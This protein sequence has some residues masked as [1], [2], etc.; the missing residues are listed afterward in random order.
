MGVTAIVISAAVVTAPF[1]IY[2]AIKG[3]KYV[4]QVIKEK[5][6][7]Q[8][9]TKNTGENLAILKEE[10]QSDL[11]GANL[12]M[13]GEDEVSK[14]INEIRND[15][16]NQYKMKI[17]VTKEDNS[18]V[19][20][21][22]E[23]VNLNDINKIFNKSYS[24]SSEIICINN[25][26]IF[27]DSYFT[28]MFRIKWENLNE[29]IL[30]HN[31]ITKVTPLTNFPLINL[32]KLDLSYNLIEDIDDFQ[33]VN[34]IKLI[35]VNFKNNKIDSPAAFINK[36]FYSLKY[37]NLLNNDIDDSDKGKFIKKYKAKNPNVE[38]YI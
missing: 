16:V 30:T 32:E 28:K 10:V 6:K 4:Y 12:K 31:K 24:F 29:L 20:L 33:E 21:E 26:T 5:N 25:Y 8:L 22:E 1:L 2:G 3:I 13:E 38:L 19:H 15:N 37:L 7:T 36:I 23:S 35:S 27:N 18:Q 11:K 34:M 17:L 14:L 9:E